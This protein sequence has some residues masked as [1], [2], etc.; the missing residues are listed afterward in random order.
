[1]KTE[2]PRAT[3]TRVDDK[4]RL[5]AHVD[6]Q[7]AGLV[8]YIPTKG[9]LAFVHTEVL[10]ER[11]GQGIGSALAHASLEM[12]R[13]ADLKFLPVCPFIASWADR[14]PEYEPWRYRSAG[15]VS[16]WGG[17]ESPRRVDPAKPHDG[18]PR[19]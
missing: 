3:V 13:R 7:L 5:E 14:H 12:V 4:N 11:E 16:D 17:P 2:K 10:P 8:E 9:L 18:G 15:R 19:C 1:M 6:G